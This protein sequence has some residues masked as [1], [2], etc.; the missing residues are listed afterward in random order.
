VRALLRLAVELEVL[1]LL[2]QLLA[3]RLGRGLEN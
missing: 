2:A 1:D 3:E